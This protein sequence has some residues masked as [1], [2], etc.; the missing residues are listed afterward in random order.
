MSAE[1]EQVGGTFT[2]ADVQAWLDT[3]DDKERGM[4]AHVMAE[5]E[6]GAQMA[7]LSFAIEACATLA[8][9]HASEHRESSSRAVRGVLDVL[10]NALR[11]FKAQHDL[12]TVAS[13]EL[14]EG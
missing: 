4:L 7:G 9:E 3:L 1:H 5:R 13:A 2:R 8:Q 11:R 14:A 6:H 10:A 12:E